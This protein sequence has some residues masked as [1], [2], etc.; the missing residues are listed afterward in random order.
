MMNERYGVGLETLIDLL[1]EKNNYLRAKQET[2]QSKYMA[3][4]NMELLKCYTGQKEYR[5]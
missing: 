3:L 4:L 1:T 5:K 2:L